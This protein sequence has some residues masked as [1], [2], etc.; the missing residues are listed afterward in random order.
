MKPDPIYITEDI[1]I[2]ELKATPRFEDDHE[3]R[4]AKKMEGSLEIGYGSAK[5]IKALTFIKGHRIMGPKI[6][7]SKGLIIR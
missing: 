6:K 2:Q 4:L 7:R 5:A 3:P 1:T